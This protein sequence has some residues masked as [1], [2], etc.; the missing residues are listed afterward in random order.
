MKNLPPPDTA[1]RLEFKFIIAVMASHRPAYLSLLL[2]VLERIPR[3]ESVLLVVSHDGLD[4]ATVKL[5]SGAVRRL[6]VKQL[7]RECSGP[8]L[9]H[10]SRLIVSA[11]ITSD[12][13][14]FWQCRSRVRCS[15]STSRPP[16]RRTALATS[17][18]QAHPRRR[19]AAR[20]IPTSTGGTGARRR[21]L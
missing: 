21:W 6:R 11:Q 8:A 10:S 9:A 5:V 16:A 1:G 2:Q 19:P 20:G 15:V 7:F 17:N 3:P 13:R 12:R 14:M 4:E 18:G